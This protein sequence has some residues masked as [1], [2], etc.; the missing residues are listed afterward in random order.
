MSLG[1][2][3]RRPRCLLVWSVASLGLS[4]IVL[5]T[6][7]RTGAIVSALA[8]GRLARTP[9]DVALTDLAADVLVGC[10]TWLWLVTTVVV[11]EAARGVAGGERARRGVPACVRRIV[12]GA[13]GVALVGG[14]A[15]P[16]YALSPQTHRAHSDRADRPRPPR[17]L[18]GLPVPDRAVA[19]RPGR[20]PAPS[21]ETV[22]VAPGD[23]LWAI[24]AHGLPAHSPDARIAVRWHAIYAANRSLIGPDPDLIVPGQ[25]LL[26]PGKETS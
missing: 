14:L 19:P 26:L 15:Q 20:R 8:D 16:S 13:C 25:R 11:V 24:A 5:A 2:P 18:A 9:L 1:S 22:L 12:L 10:A 7:A 17:G 4:L 3:G 23:T 21:P 6:G